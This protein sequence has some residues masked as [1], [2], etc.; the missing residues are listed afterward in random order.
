MKCVL[1]GKGST[2]TRPKLPLPVGHA[3]AFRITGG[4][5]ECHCHSALGPGRL[6][7]LPVCRADHVDLFEGSVIQTRTY[8][9]GSPSCLVTLM[10]SDL[11]NIPHLTRPGLARLGLLARLGATHALLSDPRRVEAQAGQP[12]QHTI[13]DLNRGPRSRWDCRSMGSNGQLPLQ[14]R[15]RPVVARRQCRRGY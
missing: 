9:G 8:L 3:A 1:C 5:G 7:G 12:R 2:L 11:G 13:L 14:A 15:T 10:A 6:C 4:M